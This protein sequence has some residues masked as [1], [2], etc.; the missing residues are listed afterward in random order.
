M[1]K[2]GLPDAWFGTGKQEGQR[3]R[4]GLD[5]PATEVSDVIMFNFSLAGKTQEPEF[6]DKKKE[7]KDKRESA[8]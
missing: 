5:A 6:W 8:W 1:K 2:R 4:G 3:S 7:G